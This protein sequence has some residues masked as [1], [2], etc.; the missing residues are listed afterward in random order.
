[1]VRNANEHWVLWAKDFWRNL[2]YPESEDNFVDQVTT[3]KRLEKI[4]EDAH[5]LKL[6]EDAGM[7]EFENAKVLIDEKQLK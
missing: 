2:L 3:E 1:M 4:I 6:S 5:S 7:E